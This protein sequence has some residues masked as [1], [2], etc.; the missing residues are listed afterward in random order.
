MLD[1][2]EKFA[3]REDLEVPLGVPTAAGSIDRLAGEFLPS[4]LL[5]GER[6]PQ[7]VFGQS[8]PAMDVVGTDGIFP[9][10]EALP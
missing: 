10:V 2:G 4:D 5:Q 8:L 6:G 3:G 1:G 9:C 7:K